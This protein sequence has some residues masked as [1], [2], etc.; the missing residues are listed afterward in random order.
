MSVAQAAA[1]GV[2]WNMVFGVGARLVQLV[3]TLVLT[4]F[5]APD[6]YGAVLA[7]SIA[8]MTAGVLTTFAFGQYIIAHRAG[9]KVVFQAM[10]VHVAL[11]ACAM[12]PL[13]ALRNPLG[14]WFDSPA[15]APF[16][17]GYAVAHM[18][19]RVRYVP[20]RVVI[21]ALRFRATATINGSGE[22]L[23][24]AVALAMA[25]RFG[26]YAIMAA[27]IARSAFGCLASLAVAPRDEWLAPGPLERATI[28]ELFAYGVPITVAAIADRAATRWDNLVMSKLF[29]PAVMGRYNLSY[30]LA[31]V[32][33]SNVAEHIGEVLMPS[34]SRMEE[35]ERRSASVRAAALMSLV[36]SPL[37]VGLAAVAPTLVSTFFD[38]RW[39]QMS[40]MLVILS[41]MTVFRPMTWSSIA[42]ML[43]IKRTKV[44]M[45]LSFARAIGVLSLL[46]LFGLAGGE[47][48][49][50]VG[51]CV[52]IALH[53]IATIVV[54]GR[55][56][57]FATGRYLAGVLRPL[58][59]C[60]PM[61]LAVVLARGPLEALALPRGVALGCEILL[62][63]IVFVVSALIVAAPTSRELIRLARRTLKRG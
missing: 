47:L 55:V 56:A 15:M 34:F 39:A 9:P 51:A 63:G 12:A 41:V 44:V 3:G 21:R 7:A 6:A 19:D 18:L 32:P 33:V 36:V 31:E 22:L 20:D 43:A 14:R 59:A 37:G 25:P 27:T 53:A 2:A 13:V 52:A 4:R 10:V 38:A 48:W 35:E 46:A 26:A 61:F 58:V 42:Y 54:G 5:I 60:V 57:G 30:S 29:G 11:G 40:T 50:C 16:M 28:R 1:R 8:V 17:L 62:G 45:V 23:F 24:T 49:A